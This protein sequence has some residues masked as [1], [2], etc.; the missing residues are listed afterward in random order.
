MLV[1]IAYGTIIIKSVNDL[2]YAL[3]EIPPN[4]DHHR[5]KDSPSMRVVVELT[6]N[7]KYKREVPSEV[8][9]DI[10]HAPASMKKPLYPKGK[11]SRDF[12]RPAEPIDSRDGRVI[13]TLK[14]RLGECTGQQIVEDIR[15]RID[16]LKETGFVLSPQSYNSSAVEAA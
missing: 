1:K 16:K 4:I 12:S 9:P 14:Q 10:D 15:S 13:I 8:D 7:G 5:A 6:L 2:V 3:A 11:K